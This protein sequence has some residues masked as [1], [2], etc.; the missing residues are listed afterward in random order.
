MSVRFFFTSQKLIPAVSPAMATMKTE[1]VQYSSVSHT[2]TAHSWKITNGWT[3][4]RSS[5]TYQGGM[6]MSITLRPT[7]T[8]RDANSLLARPDASGVTAS[9]YASGRDNAYPRSAGSNRYR[10]CRHTT[11]R[12]GSGRE[13]GGEARATAAAAAGGSS[14]S[15]SSAIAS[16]RQHA[17]SPSDAVTRS[18]SASASVQGRARSRVARRTHPGHCAMMDVVPRVSTESTRC[19][20]TRQG[21]HCSGSTRVADNGESSRSSAARRA[22]AAAGRGANP[23]GRGNEG[24]GLLIV[25]QRLKRQ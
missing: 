13:E 16:T 6:A 18:R 2:I 8:S 7:R 12:E 1:N 24:A 17:T 15:G 11:I 14:S 23:G 25:R 19:A 4:S 10:E 20:V 21:T 22:V 5:S 9:P 3:H